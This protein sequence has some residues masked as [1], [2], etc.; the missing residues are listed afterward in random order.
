M[1]VKKELSG[2]LHLEESVSD[3][4]GADAR[5]AKTESRRSCR[6][7]AFAIYLRNWKGFVAD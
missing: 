7:E 6:S 3:R 1:S 2:D 5:A 4:F